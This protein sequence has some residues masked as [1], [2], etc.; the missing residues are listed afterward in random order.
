MFSPYVCD[1]AEAALFGGFPF[2]GCCISTFHSRHNKIDLVFKDTCLILC[3]LSLV[4]FTLVA[5]ARSLSVTNSYV[6]DCMR[7]SLELTKMCIPDHIIVH[8]P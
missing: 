4:L 5:K 2:L 7:Q 8:I 6:G 1:A 3:T